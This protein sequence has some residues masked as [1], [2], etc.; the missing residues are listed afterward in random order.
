[1]EKQINKLLNAY[2]NRLI[3]K[4]NENIKGNRQ[5]MYGGNDELKETFFIFYEKNDEYFIDI[6]CCYEYGDFEYGRF[7]F[8]E[9]GFEIT[10]K[11]K[12]EPDIYDNLLEELDFN[13]GIFGT[14]IVD[15]GILNE[16]VCMV[17][18]DESI[19]KNNHVV[20]CKVDEDIFFINNDEKIKLAHAF[21]KTLQIQKNEN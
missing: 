21:I 19:I 14:C 10:R 3:W 12:L 20:W 9:Y 17:N 8:V 18:Y 13:C 4:F 1:M 6:G 11:I 7:N 2:E 5:Y 16:D 15:Y